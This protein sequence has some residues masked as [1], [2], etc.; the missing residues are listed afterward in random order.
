MVCF[1]YF[2]I[3]MKDRPGPI[4]SFF[5]GASLGLAVLTKATAYIVG[6]PFAVWIGFESIRSTRVGAI[7]YG[8]ICALLVFAINGGHFSRNVQ[9]YGHPMAPLDYR[10]SN[11]SEK[12]G[13]G[14][15]FSSVLR[16]IALHMGTP[17]QE[18]NL[19]FQK[20]MEDVHNL[21]GLD[22][23]DTDTTFG[24]TRFSVAFSVNEDCTGN[25]IHCVLALFCFILLLARS[26]KMRWTCPSNLRRCWEVFSF[27]V[28]TSNGTPGTADINFHV[29]AFGSG[30]RKFVAR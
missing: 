15:I 23:N 24:D 10:N 16:N 28:F 20:R 12:K 17:V 3:L 26:R 2:G 27:S 18:V 9:L 14:A 8:C 4:R 1:L 22:A 19:F 29:R 6:F 25:P 13:T 11:I 21:L 7:K 30:G 5:T